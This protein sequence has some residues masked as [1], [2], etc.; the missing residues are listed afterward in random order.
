ME[1]FLGEIRMFGGTFAPVGWNLCDGTLLSIS[2]YSGLYSLIGTVW[3][4]NGTTNFA[5]PDLRGRLPVGQGQG[6][7]LTNR[8]LGPSGGGVSQ[9]QLTQAQMP[10]HS[11]SFYAT[12]SGGTAVNAGGNVLAA[13]T[14]PASGAVYGY[15][16]GT[17][18][19]TGIMDPHTISYAGAS[20]YHTNLMPYQAVN[21]IIAL[22]GLYPTRQ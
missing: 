5:V 11:H 3:G 14:Q 16:S 20:Q 10:A 7:G 18:S 4:G 6:T 12:S 13:L 2:E 21:F 1:P 15:A 19:A 8:T 17:T 22:T 9:V